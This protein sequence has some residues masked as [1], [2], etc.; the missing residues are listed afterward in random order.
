MNNRVEL[1]KKA[2]ELIREIAERGAASW[3]P[4]VVGYALQELSQVLYER[5]G[6]DERM[7]EPIPAGEIADLYR[8]LGKLDWV[9]GF[10]CD[11]CRCERCN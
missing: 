7:L 2:L 11:M 8:L 3:D 9:D 6:S 5:T 1:A 10:L 4:A